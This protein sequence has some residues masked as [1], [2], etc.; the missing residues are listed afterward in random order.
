[1]VFATTAGR[2]AP[3][4]L[5]RCS[6]DAECHTPGTHCDQ[7]IGCVL[8]S[9]GSCVDASC[10]P[11]STCVPAPVAVAAHDSDSDGVPDHR[12][13]CPFIPNADQTDTD[14]DGV[15]DPCDIRPCPDPSQCA[16]PVNHFKCR[17]AVTPRGVTSFSPQQ[18]TLADR[19]QS[20]SVTATRR[21]GFCSP[22][23]QD[24]SGISDPGAHLTCY[25]V[26]GGNP[27]VGD[28]VVRDSFGS[29]TL[30][31]GG[32]DRLCVP[33][34]IG[35][36]PS[37][38]ADRFACYKARTKPGTPKFPH[39]EVDLTDEFETTPRTV[40]VTHPMFFCAPVDV[41][42][43]G[44]HSPTTFLSCYQM[45]DAIRPRFEPHVID[46]HDE[47]GS[48]PLSVRRPTRPLCVPAALGP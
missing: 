42:G 21:L 2:C 13:N 12:D 47:F 16:F 37:A 32:L 15:G 26:L 27:A 40:L 4:P 5:T 14:N 30:S 29:Q 7:A 8:R 22:V 39:T 25:R 36:P 9:P 45:R 3:T 34:D 23:D 44:I 31:L 48:G 41:N 17:R 35:V 38:V 24:G 28:L 11:G 19:F 18:M 43:A 10:P 46:E 20:A 33:S 6:T 1:M